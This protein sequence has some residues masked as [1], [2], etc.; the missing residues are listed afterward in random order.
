MLST[1]LAVEPGLLRHR[2]RALPR[3]A[4]SS[5]VPVPARFLWMAWN[6]ATPSAMFGLAVTI[7]QTTSLSS[8]AAAVPNSAGMRVKASRS[9]LMITCRVMPMTLPQVSTR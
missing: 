1:R 6:S 8:V 9:S 3:L 2:A 7:P 5:A 4:T